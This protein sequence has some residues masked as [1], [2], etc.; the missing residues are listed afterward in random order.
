MAKQKNVTFVD[1]ARKRLRR[2]A[3]TQAAYVEQTNDPEK[4]ERKVRLLK[5]AEAKRKARA[6]RRGSK[7]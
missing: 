7:L 2:G 4:W 6:K 1:W 3:T 5:E